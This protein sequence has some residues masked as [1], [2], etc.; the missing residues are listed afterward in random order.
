MSNI[1]LITDSASDIMPEVAAK[2]DIEVIPFSVIIDGVEYQS[3]VNLTNEEFYKKLKSCKETPKTSLVSPE[4]IYETFKKHIEAGKEVF[5]ITISSVASGFFNSARIASEMIVDNYP[6][7]KIKVLD[8]KKFAYVYGLAMTE[9]YRLAEEGKTL[10]EI[11][12]YCEKFLD[13]F[14]VYAVPE[15]LVY[16]EKGGRINKA[17]LVFGTALDLKPIIGIRKGLI[18]SLGMLRG[19][20]KIPQ[21]LIKKI[22]ETGASQE[23]K[24]VIIVN[25]DMD[26]TVKE[27]KALVEEELKPKEIIVSPIGPTI[28]T[29]VGPV[30]GIFFHKSK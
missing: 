5:M 30:F 24:T 8:S 6:D 3:G 27:F 1:K 19:T 20:K 18:E 22:K 14:E 7:A 21:K 16:L 23:G 25:G 10:D 2:Y 28:G 26:E 11:Y 9:A 12:D 13:D 4:I 29:H 17:S 15:S